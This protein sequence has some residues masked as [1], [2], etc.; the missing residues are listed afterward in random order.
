MDFFYF[1]RHFSSCSHSFFLFYHAIH[2]VE[3]AI[4]LKR[5][6][7][8]LRLPV[9]LTIN[10]KLDTRFP[11]VPKSMTLDDPERPFSHSVSKHM[12]LSE[13]TGC[14]DSRFLGQSFQSVTLILTRFV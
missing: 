11:L 13:T 1:F 9:L 6:K 3:N 5:G 8:G 4:S 2:Y 10:R 12:R 14:T 7:I